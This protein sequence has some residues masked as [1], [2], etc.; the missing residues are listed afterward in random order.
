MRTSDE[1]QLYPQSPNLS[2][3]NDEPEAETTAKKSSCMSSLFADLSQLAT[4]RC[5]LFTKFVGQTSELLSAIQPQ[6]PAGRGQLKVPDKHTASFWAALAE[7]KISSLTLLT[8]L[9]AHSSNSSEWHDWPKRHILHPLKWRGAFEQV[10]S[11]GEAEAEN[12]QWWNKTLRSLKRQK[13]HCYT[14]AWKSGR[15]HV[16]R[17]MQVLKEVK[18]QTSDIFS[19]LT[20]QN[21]NKVKITT[22]FFQPERELG[23]TQLQWGSNTGVSPR[24]TKYQE[25]GLG[26]T[27]KSTEIQAGLGKQESGQNA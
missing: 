23:T 17:G 25:R 27:E 5:A 13:C 4:S 22:T 15:Y 3:C 10:A 16:Q 20:E 6:C 24:W 11:T 21:C 12:L 19:P 26:S 8:H 2:T 1:I 7:A 14:N 18:G 9:F